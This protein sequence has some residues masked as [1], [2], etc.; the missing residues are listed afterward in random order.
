MLP[1]V[2]HRTLSWASWIPSIRSQTVSL[3]CI[4][5]FF[6][7]LSSG[8]S[9]AI[10]S[11]QNMWISCPAYG[12]FFDPTTIIIFVEKYKT[13]ISLQFF[14]P[15]VALCHTCSI[16]FT[17]DMGQIFTTITYT[18]FWGGGGRLSPLGTSATNWPIVPDPDNDDDECGA[19]GGMRVSRGNQSTR[20][21]TCPS[22]T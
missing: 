7:C 20:K 11:D 12:T 15:L 16:C 8:L 9:S 4:V 21:K 10:Y 6:C 13:W 3:K 2:L 22:A 17:Q 5:I 18:Q 14:R 1:R 19:V